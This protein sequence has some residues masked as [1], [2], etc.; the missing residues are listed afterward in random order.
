MTFLGV[1]GEEG[2]CLLPLLGIR[3]K[4]GI[5]EETKQNKNRKSLP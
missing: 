4:F 5:Y 2:L 3:D 1:D